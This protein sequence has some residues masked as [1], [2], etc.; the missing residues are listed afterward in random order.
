[1][2]QKARLVGVDIFRGF[3]VYAV[4]LL[5]SD[6][7]V[8]ALPPGWPW[9]LR[10]A[11]FA[12]PFFLATSFYFA[13]DPIYQARKYFRLKARL[14]R[15]AV[16][17]AF[18]TVAYLS[19]KAAKYWVSQDFEQL[20][21]IWHDPVAIIF[22][23]GAAFHLYF[24]PLLL[25]GTVLIEPLRDWIKKCRQPFVL[26]L[27][28]IAS[29]LLY[30]LILGTGNAFE[31]GP[32]TAFKTLV[33]QTFLSNQNPIVRLLL[34]QIAWI[35]RCLPYLS[36][37]VLLSYV[38]IDQRLSKLN[39]VGRLGLVVAFGI[40]NTVGGYFLPAAIQELGQGYCG[41][42]L[43]IALST[44]L[45]PKIREHPAISSLSVCSF[46]IY[47]LHLFVVEGFQI[48]GPRLY[49]GF[50]N[51]FSALGLMALALASFVISWLITAGFT[52]SRILSRL[53]FGI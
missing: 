13:I 10:F 16:P 48:V 43:A 11:G 28:C 25:A 22:L 12:V 47:L 32:N 9:V 46:G 36:M 44:A 24:L 21:E 23:G 40:V 1:M 39:W 17:Y 6:E 2:R 14:W 42:L 50:I 35:V 38:G 31:L 26:G 49:P 52:R 33:E 18:W 34:V 5:H 51:Q 15:L 7:G 41:L 37:A 4:V 27:F 20:R 8:I 53:M 3:A 19:Y 30:E 45:S 29:L